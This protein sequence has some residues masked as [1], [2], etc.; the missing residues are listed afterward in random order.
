MRGKEEIEQSKIFCA[1]AADFVE[2]L[3]LFGDFVRSAASSLSLDHPVLHSHIPIHV[4]VV[5]I[6]KL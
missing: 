2:Y 5:D 4:F 1:V 3:L 6:I